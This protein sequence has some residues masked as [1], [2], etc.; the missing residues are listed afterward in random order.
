VLALAGCG[1]SSSASSSSNAADARLKLDQCMR[2]HGVNLP[3]PGRS[4]GPRRIQIAPAKFDA[5]RKACAKYADAAFPKLSPQQR[6]ELQD[7]IVKFA[8]C[9]RSHGVNVP[10]PTT[11]GRGI[12]FFRRRGSGGPNPDSP[13]FQA[14]QKAC[15]SLLPKPPGGGGGLRTVGPGPSGGKGGPSGSVAVG[16]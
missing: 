9:M 3:D 15:Q 11:N 10:D 1:A 7:R 14:A 2:K 8:R 5:A 16:P 12:G 4:G 6:A 13:A